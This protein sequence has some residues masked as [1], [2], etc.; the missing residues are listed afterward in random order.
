MLVC[1]A[2]IVFGKGVMG[3]AGHLLGFQEVLQNGGILF[4]ASLGVALWNERPNSSGTGKSSHL[5]NVLLLGALTVALWFAYR[6][7]GETLKEGFSALINVYMD[8]W[9][10]HT[11]QYYRK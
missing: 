3:L 2:Y 6:E 7:S 10:A 4:L 1:L 5:G 9:K 8:R 11:Y